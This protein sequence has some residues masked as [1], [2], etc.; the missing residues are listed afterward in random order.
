M[1]RR[2]AVRAT[3][4]T[5]EDRNRESSELV[6]VSVVR[7]RGASYEFRYY[8]P[9]SM[10]ASTVRAFTGYGGMLRSHLEHDLYIG[11]LRLPCI[12]SLW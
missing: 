6:A 12:E 9:L 8:V 5:E 4:S 1:R 3:F 10:H 2:S 11:S 7:D